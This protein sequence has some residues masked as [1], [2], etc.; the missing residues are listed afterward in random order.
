MRYDSEAS[1][2]AAGTGDS[3][4]QYLGTYTFSA[5]LYYEAV[6]SGKLHAAPR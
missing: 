1:S 6:A 2:R 4:T 3:R 5:W